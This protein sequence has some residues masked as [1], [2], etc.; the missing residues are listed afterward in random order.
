MLTE[1][2]FSVHMRTNAIGLHNKKLC[3]DGQTSYTIRNCKDERLH[4]KKLFKWT[5]ITVTEN[6]GQAGKAHKK[7]RNEAICV[8]F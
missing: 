3:Q 6:V 2:I 7:R 5:I 1:A 8:T 4:K